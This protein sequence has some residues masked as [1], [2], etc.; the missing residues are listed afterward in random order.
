M[1]PPYFSALA[2]TLVATLGLSACGDKSDP[3]AAA[4]PRPVRLLTVGGGSAANTVELAGAVRARVASRLGFRVA[5]KIIS[6]HVEVGQHVHKGDELMRL[7]PRDYQLSELAAKSGVTSAQATLDVAQSEYDRFSNLR[8]KGFVSETDLEKK[9]TELAAAK[10]Q[11][12]NAQSTSAI[13]TNRVADAV[14]RADV[15]GVVDSISADAGEVVNTGQ[16][17]VTLAR[18][19]EREIEVEFPEDQ[20]ALAKMAKAEVRLWAKQ[21]SWYPATLRELSA[22]ADPQSR[23]FRARYTVQA[24]AGALALGQSATLRLSVSTPVSGGVYVPTNALVDNQGKT[25]VWLYDASSSQVR[26]TPVSVLGVDGN[27]VLVAGLANGAQ[28]VTAGVHIIT[29]GQKVRPLDE[30]R[31]TENSQH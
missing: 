24:P 5:G 16:P 25:S 18:D 19:G 12:A 30:P 6:R 22:S 13:E 17:V 15:D 26:R 7:D 27:R 28:V 10:A 29:D 20:T 21:D 23:T 1:K 3:A 14:L 31:L 9:R 2:V 8:Q 11:L 4:Q